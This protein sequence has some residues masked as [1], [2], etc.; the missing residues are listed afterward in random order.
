MPDFTVSPLSV[1]NQIKSN[2]QDRYDSGFPILKELL[3]NADDAHARHV[4][5]DCRC[6]W[7][8][9]DNPLLS[10]P[11]LLIVNDGE[12]R[13]KDRHDILA[14]GESG[15]AADHAAIGKFGLGQKAVFHLCD[16]FVVHALDED[17]REPFSKVVN[18]FL[19]LEVPNNVARKWEDLSQSDV[20]C[21]RGAVSDSYTRGLILWLP[22][23]SDRLQPAPGLS[24]STN[25]PS[26]SKTVDELAKTEELQTL[27]TLLRHLESIEIRRQDGRDSAPIT[28]C[29]V[30]MRE[31]TTRLRGPQERLG[32]RRF[33]GA[34]DYRN[35]REPAL[36]VGR[37]AM[38]PNDRLTTLQRR[39]HWPKA[40]DVRDAQPK[41]EKGEPHGAATLL[42]TMNDPELKPNEL[43][44]SWAVFLPISDQENKALRAR[45][46]AASSDFG[47]ARDLGRFRLLLHGYFFLDSGRRHIDGLRQQAPTDAPSSDTEVRRAWNA[48]LRDSVV[49]PLIPAVLKDA[50]DDKMVTS[51]ELAALTAAIAQDDWFD[52]NRLA[53]CKNEALVRALDV[54]MGITWSL[55]SAGTAIRPLPPSVAARPERVRELFEAVHSWADER[56]ITLC[57]DVS[58]SLMPEPM[59]WTA[60]ELG[61]LCSAL[62][63][64]VFLS[65]ALASLLVDFLHLAI[66]HDDHR[67]TIAPHIVRALRAAL[68]DRHKHRLAPS[69]DVAGILAHLPLTAF[70]PLP[71]GVEHRQVLRA[72]ALQD[73][74]VLPSE[75]PSFYYVNRIGQKSYR[76]RT[77]GSSEGLQN[78][79]P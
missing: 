14:F 35:A 71:T 38:S 22:F 23:R 17:E 29:V 8:Q 75:I 13:Q 31:V 58:A 72:L 34:I 74:T 33:G 18:P 43:T 15:K 11:G 63:S 41:R 47:N 39:D 45:P 9:A 4:R 78:S 19:R 10:G 54:K 26:I 40:I 79:A 46:P 1:V 30:R 77:S 36:F 76:D 12:F 50:L 65:P 61:S 55:V 2:L 73:T 24:F 67:R 21:L 57:V 49:L 59:Q 5:L 48:E 69:E 28:R 62:T 53:I 64:R 6:G 37:E 27:L 20:D 52:G 56:G 3:Q 25:R 44:I 16:A 70:F 51:A 32:T 68:R 7:H 66:S 60:E 42:R